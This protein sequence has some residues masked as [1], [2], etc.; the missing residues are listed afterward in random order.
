MRWLLAAALVLC[1]ALRAHALPTFVTKFLL[2][3]NTEAPPA[4]AEKARAYI[5]DLAAREAIRLGNWTLEVAAG[6]GLGQGPEAPEA[7]AP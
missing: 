5:A 1:A 2:P 3:N 7:P 6:Q 4:L